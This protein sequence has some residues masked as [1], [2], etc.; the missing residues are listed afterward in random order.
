M[1]WSHGKVM[2]SYV[3]LENDFQYGVVSDVDVM[4]TW[5]D[6]AVIGAVGKISHSYSGAVHLW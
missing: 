5:E 1:H 6:D 4:V 2:L 3:W